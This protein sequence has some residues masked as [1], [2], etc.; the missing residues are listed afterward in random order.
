MCARVGRATVNGGVRDRVGWKLSLKAQ[1]QNIL[2]LRDSCSPS[3]A[4]KS[5]FHTESRIIVSF[6]LPC[7]DFSSD[8]PLPGEQSAN[9]LAWWLRCPQPAFILLLQTIAHCIPYAQRTWSSTCSAVFR[10]QP[11]H[12]HFF[13]FADFIL[14]AYELLSSYFHSPSP[15]T[16]FWN[17]NHFSKTVY[18]I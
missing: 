1:W 17:S 7:S 4:A 15:F 5:P 18:L 8:L 10:T 16:H 3:H 6:P 13:S 11:A 2:D 12:P 9:S 14:L